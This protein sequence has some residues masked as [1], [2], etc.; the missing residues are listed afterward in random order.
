MFHSIIG[1]VCNQK[2]FSGL[3]LFTAHRSQLCRR[4][5][6]CSGNVC[7]GAATE[8]TIRDGQLLAHGVSL[9]CF[10]TWW[11]VISSRTSARC[12]LPPSKVR[13]FGILPFVKC[14]AYITIY[15]SSLKCH[16]Q[17]GG[18]VSSF[19]WFIQRKIKMPQSNF[20]LGT[21]TM[22]VFYVSSDPWTLSP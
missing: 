17:G 2:A 8:S 10:W 16:S 13:A 11:E 1:R 12:N 3:T 20:F 18:Q 7:L 9:P 14:D 4:K 15:P 5:R 21:W 6:W 19:R 22:K